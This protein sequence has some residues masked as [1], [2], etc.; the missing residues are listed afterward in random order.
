MPS[1][2]SDIAGVATSGAAAV[3]VPMGGKG[4]A[5]SNTPPGEYNH[6]QMVNLS[7]NPGWGSIDGGNSW[8]AIP[9]GVYASNQFDTPMYDLTPMVKRSGASDITVVAFAC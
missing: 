7:A 8:F 2:S 4:I 1:I 5:P 6:F 3:P 9:G